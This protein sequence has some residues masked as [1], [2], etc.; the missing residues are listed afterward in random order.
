M[1]R[2]AIALLLAFTVCVGN[3]SVFASTTSEEIV[4][5]NEEKRKDDLITVYEESL[6][7]AF[8]PLN[9]TDKVLRDEVGGFMYGCCEVVDAYDGSI[10]YGSYDSET[11]SNSITVA[12]AKKIM[13]EEYIKILEN[14]S[15]NR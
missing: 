6:N 14:D 3:Q 12:E 8:Y 4:M 1:K 10:T 15:V 2:F 11:D 13:L 9:E 7:D 5:E